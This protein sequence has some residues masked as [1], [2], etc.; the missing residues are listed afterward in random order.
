LKMR[1]EG[2][3]GGRNERP[4]VEEGLTKRMI[5][6]QKPTVSENMEDFKGQGD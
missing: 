6:G 4:L 2:S 5:K 1:Q 3:L